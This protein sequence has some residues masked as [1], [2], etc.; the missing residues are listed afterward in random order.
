[1]GWGQSKWLCSVPFPK[2]SETALY[3]ALEVTTWRTVNVVYSDPVCAV[4]I[5]G[6]CCIWCSAHLLGSRKSCT[7]PAFNY[8][9]FSG[10][11]TTWNKLLFFVFCLSHSFK[12][13]HRQ[14]LLLAVPMHSGSQ[15]EEMCQPCLGCSSAQELVPKC[16]FG[17][18]ILQLWR[19]AV[20]NKEVQMSSQHQ[21]YCGK[22]SL[23]RDPEPHLPPL[24]QRTSP[25]ICL[26][27]AG[28]GSS[29]WV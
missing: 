1:M 3:K 5:P 11:N 15:Q 16:L 10:L 23:K 19:A 26:Q 20:L 28:G 13:T 24:K 14:L 7:N 25:K 29:G 2:L 17:A 8:L 4:D 12:G 18:Q 22:M 6:F 27:S 21:E 9:S